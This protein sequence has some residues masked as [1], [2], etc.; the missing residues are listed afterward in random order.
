LIY[1]QMSSQNGNKN[2]GIDADN[3]MRNMDN[4]R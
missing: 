1:G 2:G 4:V 3:T